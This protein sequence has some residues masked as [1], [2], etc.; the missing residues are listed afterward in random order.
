[1]WLTH[2]GLP[3]ENKSL[4]EKVISS[5]GAIISE[6]PLGTAPLGRQFP[7]RNR[8]IAGLSYGVVVIEATKRSGALITVDFALEEG[9]DV[10][11]VPGSIYSVSSEG[12]NE[13]LRKGAI[14]VT[15]GDDII[16][17]YD[18]GMNLETNINKK[19][20]VSKEETLTVEEEMVY[21][22]CSTGTYIREED[23]LEQLKYSVSQLKMIL[24]SLQLK[25]KIKE[26][27]SGVFVSI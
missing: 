13:L 27:S 24:M 18:W 17:E 20:F 7:A 25:E 5:G 23:L 9:R 21:R 15:T 1:M 4:F 8:I 2:W 11:S 26:V 3:P 12:T 6:Y 16:I 14:C 10:F 19:S 22:F